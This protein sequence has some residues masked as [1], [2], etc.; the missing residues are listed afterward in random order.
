M[1]HLTASL[2]RMSLTK[3]VNNVGMSTLTNEDDPQ[4]PP[5][6]QGFRREDVGLG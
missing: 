3:V 4:E 6:L 1:T 2:S 5:V